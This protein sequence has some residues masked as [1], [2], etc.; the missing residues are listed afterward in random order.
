MPSANPKLEKQASTEAVEPIR[1]AIIVIEHKIRNLEKRKGKLES[2]KDLQKQ[3][4]VLDHDQKIAVA[5]YDEVVQTLDLT[6]EL[7]KQIGGIAND[8]AKQ[9]KK[10]ARKEALERTQ[11]DVAKVREVLMVQDCLTQLGSDKVRQDFLGGTN[12]AVKLTEDDMQIL[13]NFYVEVTLKHLNEGAEVSFLQQVQKVAE[14]FVAIVDGKQR[15]I[16][17]STYSRI[18][19]IIN[20]VHQSGYF[21]QVQEAQE[22][23]EEILETVVESQPAEPLVQEPIPDD[24]SGSERHIPPPE[25]MIPIPN[26]P[27][28]ATPLPVIPGSAP[29]PGPISVIPQ[30]IVSHAPAPV[31]ASYYTNAPAGFVPPP[32]QHQQPQQQQPQAPRINDVI[33]TPNFFFLQESEL[34]SPDV[35]A[36]A[37]VVPH[38]PP[39]GNA[40]IPSQTFTNQNFTTA[41]NVVPQQ[42]IYQHAPQDISHIPG[43]ANPNPPPPI[44][45][46]PSHQ[47]PN[48]PYSPQHPAGF[49]QPPQGQ[50]PQTI[51]QQNYEQIAIQQEPQPQIADDKVEQVQD[52][53][54][55]GEPDLAPVDNGGEWCQ[56][57]EGAGGD[58]NQPDSSPPSQQQQQPIQQAWGDQQRGGYRGRGG[59][60]GNSN[61]YS[62]RGRGGGGSGGYQQNGRGGGQG[63]YYRNNESNYQNGYQQRSYNSAEGNGGYNGSFKRGSGGGQRGGPRGDRGTDRG[64]RGQFRG[65]QRGGNRGTY[66]P[67]G[68]TQAQQ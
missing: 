1:Q 57:S 11:Q 7:C 31:E 10:L 55:G 56:L 42:V 22:Q 52:E 8:A 30:P 58:W 65:S 6:R 44:P 21:D 64:G 19:E 17:G 59:R 66:A 53:P 29:V 20:T 45:M 49:Q 38:I 46:P 39:T 28:P 67:R 14:H 5:K 62:S 9:Q 15:E 12:G 47:Q 32:Q 68:K 16:A 34:D 24:Y 61:G 37:P 2:Y 51:Q 54:A 27:V 60:R 18:K 43:F 25:S 35:T 26:F 41:P 48:L 23:V 33:G 4:K 50:Q 3:G 13:D 63:T 40:P 36:Q